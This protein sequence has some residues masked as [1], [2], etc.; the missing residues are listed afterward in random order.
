[1]EYRKPTRADWRK[2]AIYPALY[3]TAISAGA[4]L[5]MPRS[6][7]GALAWA[8]LVI[9]GAF[10]LIRWHAKN[11]AY[12]CRNC[13]HEFEISIFTDAISPHG[14]RG[15]GWTYLKCPRCGTRTRAEM[16]RKQ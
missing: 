11:T 16:L 6:A 13:G 5:L 9:L 7:L 8:I 15:G 14:P 1:M 3:I 12:R 10:L 2:T 4:F